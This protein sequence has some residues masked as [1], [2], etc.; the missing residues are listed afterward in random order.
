MKPLCSAVGLFLCFSMSVAGAQVCPGIAGLIN[1]V[2]PVTGAPFT[3][4]YVHVFEAVDADT[5]RN[6]QEVHGK[7]YRDSDG[8][9]RCDV[10]NGT[11]G[12]TRFLI[13]SDPVAS[14][15]IR[16][17]LQQQ[18]ARLTHYP[19]SSSPFAPVAPPQNAESK[20]PASVRP[21]VAH[22]EEDLGSKEIE[23]LMANGRR[24]VN[25]ED[26]HTSTMEDWYSPDLKFKVLTDSDNPLGHLR[27]QLR[28]INKGNPDPSVFQVPE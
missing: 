1:L 11:T 19:R 7:L 5:N 3:A 15:S 26:G 17:N 6:H 25:T 23:R 10:E 16:M 8:R 13:V 27:D 22:T 14:V 18:T 9:T 2:G 24:Y 4:D 12:K 21:Q 28:K 20:D